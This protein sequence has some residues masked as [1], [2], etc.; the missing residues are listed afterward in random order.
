V[1]KGGVWNSVVHLHGLISDKDPQGRSLVLTSADFG[2][3]YLTERWASRFISD[4][5]RRFT[6]LFVGY[7]VEDPVVRYMM[8][9]FA[10]DRAL[11]EGVGKAYV[12]APSDEPSRRT[13]AE[14]WEAKGVIPLLYDDSD[15]HKALHFTLAQWAD[16]HTSG[17]LGRDSIISEHAASK[18]PIKPL[19]ADPVVS[20]VVW[21]ISEPTGHTAQV[22]ARLD[23]L[24]PLEWLEV[25]AERALF[26]LPVSP[27]DGGIRSALVDA[28]Y[29][30]NNPS[31]LHPVTRA[32]GEW[33]VRHI[34]NPDLLNWVLRAGCSLHPDFRDVLR[35]QLRTAP[36]LAS[37]LKQ[38]WEILASDVPVLWRK[39]HWSWFHLHDRLPAGE[40]NTLLRLE[41]LDAIT[42]VLALEPATLPRLFPDLP[43][44]ET[45]TIHYSDAQ[46]T[47]RCH[48][49]AT[50]IRDAIARSPNREQLLTDVTDDLTTLLKRALELFEMVQKADHQ[51]D[52]SYS[53]Q[54]SISP[55]EQNSGLRDWTVLVELVR[56]AWKQVLKT[57][58]ERARR[59][60]ERWRTIPYPVFRRLCFYAMT[61]SDLYFPQEQLAYLL[62]DEGWWLWSVYV[63]REK[64]R[65]LD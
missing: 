15:G 40:W 8:D 50:L 24:P 36:K 17:L 41:L 60:I 34:D 14:T 7:S 38:I 57:D 22:F 3:A 31:P 54:P 58:R 12:L 4:L 28:G 32:L 29:R 26:S 21:A 9:A 59:L 65:L 30:S 6:I 11:G 62:E 61:E 35:R 42:P 13:N 25:F 1:P 56:D 63:Y 47:L 10:A 27:E 37:G 48:D 19:D 23:P 53:D 43:L 44:D 2:A 39:A 16:C 33:L 55:H 49:H 45:K 20:Q 46:V 18:R 52:S 5:F 51:Y 64:C